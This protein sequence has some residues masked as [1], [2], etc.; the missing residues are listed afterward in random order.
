MRAC[1]DY[2]HGYGYIVGWECTTCHSPSWPTVPVHNEAYVSSVH[3]TSAC[4]QCHSTSLITEHGKYPT[5]SVFK[6]QCQICHAT[7]NPVVN[8]AVAA[9]D[10]RCETCHTSANHLALHEGSPA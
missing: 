5:D 10:T 8:A 6:Y 9:N 7:S 1:H 4:T 2:D 3:T